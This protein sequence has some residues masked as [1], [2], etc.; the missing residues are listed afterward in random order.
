MDPVKFLREG[1]NDNVTEVL[2]PT[3]TLLGLT[4][5]GCQIF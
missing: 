3:P 5:N 1:I 4:L 2:A